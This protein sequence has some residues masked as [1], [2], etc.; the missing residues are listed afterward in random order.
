MLVPL[1][2]G[3]V[4]AAGAALWRW[5]RARVVERDALQ[6][7]PIGADGLIVGGADFTLPRQGAPAVLLIHG[8]GDTPSA[9]RY[10][11]PALHDAGYAVRAPLLPGH[12]RT[13]RDFRGVT[14]DAWT[15][16]MHEE[17]L[18]LGARHEW[19]AVV[20][21]SMGGALAV[22]LA[23]AEAT[24][25]RIAALVLLAPYLEPPP[26]VRY[27][28]LGSR[29]WGTLVPY[30]DSVDP[31]SIQD[32]AERDRSRGYGVMTPAAL[33]ALVTTAD[34]A[35]AV[36]DQVT[37]PTLM[38]QSRH[39]NRVTADACNRAYARLGAAD[40]HLDLRDE[41]GHILPVD[42][43]RERVI[44]GIMEWLAAHGGRPVTASPE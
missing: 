39:D 43:G 16:A 11:G 9:F 28:A 13:I 32:A 38:M 41:G 21:L 1:A 40:K 36:L 17:L 14:A 44:A 2:I 22:Q 19:V 5:R 7:R 20:G 35:A 33:R 25:D 30:V 27:G 31:R 37:T 24:R 10:L 29:V 4:A 26:L 8:A 42:L 23:A 3:G 15:A 34:R 6:R 12:G 18:R